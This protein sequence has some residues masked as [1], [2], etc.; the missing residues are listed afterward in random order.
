MASPP[1]VKNPEPK[2]VVVAQRKGGVGKTTIAVSVAAEFRSRGADVVLIDADPLRSASQWAEL[3]GL[4]YPI[5]ELAFPMNQPSVEWAHAVKRVRGNY[6]VIDTPPFDAALAA[7]IA[8]ANVVLIPCTPSGL[9]LEATSRTLEVVNNHRKKLAG[10]LEVILVPNRVDRRTL[11][12]RQLTEEMERFG[13]IVASA[14]SNRSAFVRS[15]SIGNSVGEFD[16]S[17]SA[18]REIRELCDLVAAS[19]GAGSNA[20]RI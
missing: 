15:F 1:A 17:G 9:D 6:I 7:S 5:Q 10:D 20:T 12:G 18:V 19:L 8:L 4:H 2:R 16:P 14:I 13:E 3:G 11:E